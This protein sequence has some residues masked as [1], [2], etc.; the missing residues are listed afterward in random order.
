MKIIFGLGNPGLRYSAT[1]HNC[2]FMTLDSLAY[3]LD[4]SFG[5]KELDNQLA[6]AVWR[7]EKLLLA[8]PQ[9]FMNL[10]GFPVMRLVNYYKVELAEILVIHDDLD[11]PPAALRL[12]R[13]GSDGGHNGIKSI[14]QQSGS[15]AI[16]R[17]KIGIGAALYDTPD[18]VLSPFSAEEAPL[19]AATF[20]LAAE[21]AC[22][23][24]ASG[25]EA[26]MNQYN[27]QD[28]AGK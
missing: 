26:A 19:F 15:T 3:Q 25:I 10:S 24:A 7:G 23:W 2:G 28:E 18:Y 8:K 5:K 1:R 12:R 21:A 16:N 20:K 6:A 27:H 11:L 17:L 22:C 9:S 4:C 14:I 13:G